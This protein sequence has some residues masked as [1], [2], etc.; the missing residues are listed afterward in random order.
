MEFFSGLKKAYDS[1]GTEISRTFDSSDFGE[2]SASR[3]EERQSA[4]EDGKEEKQVGIPINAHLTSGVV[5]C[6]CYH[7]RAS[8]ITL[9]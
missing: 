9:L 5:E 6:Q 2:G 1:I 8:W 3:A 7:S 4:E